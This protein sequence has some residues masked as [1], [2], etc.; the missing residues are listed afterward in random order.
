M[1]TFREERTTAE[2][3]VRLICSEVRAVGQPATVWLG[4]SEPE[5]EDT[6]INHFEF[7]GSDLDLELRIVRQNQPGKRMAIALQLRAMSREGL[8]F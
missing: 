1:T 2:A 3:V 8:G 7:V 5:D 4:S 6:L